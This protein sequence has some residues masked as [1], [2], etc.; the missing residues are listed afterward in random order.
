[1]GT[2]WFLDAGDLGAGAF[3]CDACNQTIAIQVVE[4]S[5]ATTLKT[6]SSFVTRK[7]LILTITS[8]SALAI[9]V[10]L[11]PFRTATFKVPGET[12]SSANLGPTFIFTSPSKVKI[13]NAIFEKDAKKL[14]GDY[15]YLYALN[16]RLDYG[17][18]LFLMTPF[19]AAALVS[20]FWLRK[21]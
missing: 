3:W 13:Y 16:S 18:T 8:C 14:S 2:Q 4:S 12:D 17:R 7:S 6:S 15:R 20:F 21:L 11:F 1:C 5:R 19:I 9:L 10:L